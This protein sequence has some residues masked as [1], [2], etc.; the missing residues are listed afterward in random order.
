M[1]SSDG[2]V[3]K[4]AL[5]DLSSL[6]GSCKRRILSLLGPSTHLFIS[7]PGPIRLVSFAVL[8]WFWP[9]AEV[10]QGPCRESRCASF[11]RSCSCTL[12]SKC[13]LFWVHRRENG[14]W[15]WT[16]L[17]LIWNEL[18]LR[19][20]GCPF[21]SF[22]LSALSVGFCVLL[23]SSSLF[24][25][26]RKKPEKKAKPTGGEGEAGQGVE[27]GGPCK[28]NTTSFLGAGGWVNIWLHG[29]WF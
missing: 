28:K 14:Q 12:H 1:A 25:L 10:T 16:S 27:G 20:E 13:W 29:F 21:P 4:V 15:S 6:V 18:L 2:R 19:T 23:W 22:Y 24:W 26:N 17:G 5:W 3:L 8:P 7:D 9:R 11:I